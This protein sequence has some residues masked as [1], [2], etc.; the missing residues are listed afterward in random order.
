MD[1][2]ES[3]LACVFA[4]ERI[5]D[6]WDEGYPL[7]L[8]NVEETGALGK[9]EFKPCKETYLRLDSSGALACFTARRGGSLI[10]YSINWVHTHAQFSQ[11]L[12][13]FQDVLY[14]AK[15]ERGFTGTRF[16]MW[17]DREL[18]RLGVQYVLRQVNDRVDYSRTLE[19]MGYQAGERTFIK[20][21]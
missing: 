11:S 6:F 7:A 17:Q 3:S 15:E 21:L 19:R 18:K 10:G 12:W 16:L 20:E 9:S 8:L 5:A 2:T 4:C 14:V 1:K 13:A